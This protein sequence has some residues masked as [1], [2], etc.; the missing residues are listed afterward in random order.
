MHK[1]TGSDGPVF[2][3]GAAENIFVRKQKVRKDRAMREDFSLDFRKY[4][5]YN[6]TRL[7]FLRAPFLI[8]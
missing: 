1:K 6:V 7:R 3:Y 5:T 8:F 4:S 2:L